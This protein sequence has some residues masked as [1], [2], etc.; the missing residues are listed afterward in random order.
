MRNL[1]EAEHV[2]EERSELWGGGWGS[3]L[4]SHLRK[5]NEPRIRF[6]RKTC[7]LGK[8]LNPHEYYLAPVTKEQK[9]QMEMLLTLCYA[10]YEMA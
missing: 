2:Q 8:H 4:H 9:K 10:R 1:S 7:L 5:E 3:L 6:H